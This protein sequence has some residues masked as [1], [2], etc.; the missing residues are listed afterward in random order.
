MLGEIV[1]GQG[2]A[3]WWAKADTI[4]A[5]VVGRTLHP[6]TI[7]LLVPDPT[8][9]HRIVDHHPWGIEPPHIRTRGWHKFCPCTLD[10]HPAF[11]ICTWR[12]AIYPPE[13]VIPGTTLIEIV[14]V[15]CLP[16]IFYGRKDVPLTY[17]PEA[18]ETKRV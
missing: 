3:T 11:M 4:I 17:D 14:A 18:I 13:T 5:K 6:G 2:K 16:E 10:G 7:N 1:R 15:R 12:R 9:E 8:N